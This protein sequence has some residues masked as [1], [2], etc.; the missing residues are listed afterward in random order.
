MF[1]LAT[2]EILPRVERPSRYLG[3]EHNSVHKDPQS[4][5]LRCC[6]AFPDS[7]DLGLGNLG[8]QIL[9]RI[10][11]ARP[12]VWAERVCAPHP[13]FEAVLR[14]HG[15]PL[16]SLESKTP[17]HEFD[18]LG[19]TL[20]WELNYTNV[21][22]MLE[23]GGV[24]PLAE[25][26][27]EGAPVV[28]AGG[29][30]VFNPEPLALFI[31][32]FVV[33]DGEE[34]IGEVAEAVMAGGGRAAV[35]DRLAGIAGCYVP[36]L[37]ATSTGPKGRVVPAP[38]APRIT[39]R[40]VRDLDAVPYPTDYLV[41][42]AEQA[43]DRVAL[44]VLRGCTQGCRFCQAGLV[45]RPVR[46][47]SLDNLARLQQEAM[48]RTGY[49][50]ISLVSLS[51]C[52]YSRSKSLVQQAVRQAHPDHINVS[53]PS[54][55][56]D[57]FSVD[58]AQ[59]MSNQRKSGLTFAPEA[60][61]D[62]MRAVINK[63][64]SRE[65]LLAMTN[66]CFRSGWD[67]IKLY[68]MIGLPTETDDDVLAIGELAREVLAGG[69][70]VNRRAKLNLGVSTFVPKPQT[71][72]QWAPQTVPD[73]A[74]RKQQL[75]RSRAWPKALKFGRADPFDSLLEGVLARGD[76]RVGWLVYY[77]WQA[78]ARFDGWYDYRLPSAWETAFGRWQ[79]EFGQDPLD[80]LSERDV[81]EPL[82][83]DHID[84]LV[85]KDW[86]RADWDR[87]RAL[88]WQLDCRRE[89]G[90][91]HRCGVIDVE[92]AVCGAMLRRSRDGA[93]ADQDLVLQPPVEAAE[94]PAVG[95]VR[96][97]WS[98]LGLVRLLSHKETMN[99]FIRAIRRARLPIRY[100]EG[101]H[102]HASL[103]FSTALPVGLETA[104]DWCDVH[105]TERIDPLE[106]ADR[107]KAELPD[108]FSLGAAW[109]VDVGEPA[110]MTVLDSAAYRVWVPRALVA[111]DLKARLADYLAQ[112]EIIAQRRGKSKGEVV[113]RPLNI[114]PM[115]RAAAL[116]ADEPEQ[117]VMD[118]LLVGHD[119]RVP[120]I[121]EVLT[122][123]L[124]RPAEDMTAVLVRKL[125]SYQ[126]VADELVEP[127]PPLAE[128]VT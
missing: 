88:E 114:R 73:E 70:A 51:T 85:S 10:L 44:E 82:P 66:Y 98:R 42:Y 46:E 126:Q 68:F 122:T 87:A 79:S 116:V 125:A 96:F 124:D 5:Q 34:V 15:W 8:L 16:F 47:R 123:L 78:G 92:P 127:Q 20:Q 54:L 28:I 109:W 36:S 2:R 19:F 112:D 74:R 60:A 80:E 100:S 67:T 118:F 49:E 110:L 84:T 21:L 99:V 91:C 30:C 29:P 27:G 119:G 69:Q 35:L 32:C 90:Q 102:P 117:A 76:R 59:G 75:L 128:Q 121:E 105:V 106:F 55:R 57:S 33:G 64:I 111:G 13:D 72:F 93:R 81:T 107:L 103:S 65:D 58:L 17:L 9:Y 56:L 22:N 108:G 45:T 120:K 101:F 62:R 39:R 6:L 26:R 14:Q 71:P 18:L 53:L 1:D 24:P 52:D 113:R 4:V 94:A 41:P 7:Y 50:E 86:L 61:T 89:G 38:D 97:R 48:R 23:L 77:A 37:L 31:D 95:R 43:H 11:N 25:Q 12:D 104:G 3:V 83:W 63:F 115:L 40:I